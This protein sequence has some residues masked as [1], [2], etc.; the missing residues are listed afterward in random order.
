MYFF[1]DLETLIGT[2]SKIWIYQ[3][4]KEL[5][6]QDLQN[7]DTKL[8]LFA[9]TWESHGTKLDAKAFILENHFVIIAA[10][11]AHFEASGCSID[12]SVQVL[13]NVN[14]EYKLDLFNRLNIAVVKNERIQFYSKAELQEELLKGNFSFEDFYLDVSV[15]SGNDISNLLKPLHQSWFYKSMVNA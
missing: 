9:N 8:A 7:I 3:F 15:V 1:K 10:N 12:K 5:V 11:E 4:K 2:R 6:I 13:R 14:E